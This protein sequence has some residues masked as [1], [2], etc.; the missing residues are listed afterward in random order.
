[1]CKVC[2]IHSSSKRGSAT[3]AWFQLV[4][5]LGYQHFKNDILSGWGYW[6]NHLWL[7]T[8]SPPHL[9]ITK[10]VLKLPNACHKYIHKKKL[11]CLEVNAHKTE[12]EA[13]KLPE[14]L[15]EVPTSGN[16]W[17]FSAGYHFPKRSA[18][19]S[20]GLIKLIKNEISP[21]IRFQVLR[22]IYMNRIKN[23]APN[24]MFYVTKLSNTK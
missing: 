15:N 6:S 14:N 24:R 3:P 1:M 5:S 23:K 8:D 2:S 12:K 20:P 7:P 11:Y 10:R 9:R 19:F 13:E 16:V 18:K 21:I 22:K 17:S 4:I